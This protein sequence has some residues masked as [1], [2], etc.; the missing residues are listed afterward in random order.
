M[1][2]QADLP[3]RQSR[4]HPLLAFALS[5]LWVGLGQVYVGRPLRA[6][7]LFV[8]FMALQVI[9][10][11]CIVFSS[12]EFKH[13]VFLVGITLLASAY[14]LG[15]RDAFIEGR[16]LG[17]F[18]GSRYKRAVW[19]AAYLALGATLLT[20]VVRIERLYLV[21]VYRVKST[22]MS[23]ALLNGDYVLVN[24]R[25]NCIDCADPLCPGDIVFFEGD[26]SVMVKRVIGLP[27][28]TVEIENQLLSVNGRRVTGDRI[29]SLGDEEL[30]YTHRS[31]S[32][33]AERLGQ[34]EYFSLWGRAESGSRE[35]SRV[36]PQSVFV[37][38]DNRHYSKDSRHFGAVPLMGVRGRGEQILFSADRH[39]GIRTGRMGMPLLSSRC[40]AATASSTDDPLLP[41]KAATHPPP[42]N[43]LI[44]TIDTLRADHVG[45]YGHSEAR[46]ATIDQLAQVSVRFENAVTS[47]PRTTPALASLFTGLWSHNH[48]SRDVG[49][50]IK[51]GRM[52]AEVLKQQGYQTHGVSSTALASG[53]QHFDRGFDDFDGRTDDMDQLLATG[54]TERALEMV[55]RASRTS[56]QFLWV[57]YFDPHFP[58]APPPGFLDKKKASACRQ[59]IRNVLD[60]PEVEWSLHSNWGRVAE[61]VRGDCI[62]LYDA[63]IEYV[64]TEIAQ[65]LHG[66]DKLGYLKSVV[67]VITSDHGESFGESGTYF[68]HGA[69]VSDAVVR[70]PLIITAPDVDAYVEPALFSLEDLTPTL[71]GLLDID[72]SGR[73]AMDGF[74]YSAR[75]RQPREA[76]H[77]PGRVL[78]AEGANSNKP[79]LFALPFDAS[80]LRSSC[81]PGRVLE[82]C[83]QF[84]GAGELL[85]AIM[86]LDARK[87]ELPASEG[88]EGARTAINGRFREGQ[89]RQRSARTQRFKLVQAPQVAGGVQRSLFD[90]ASDPR[91]TIDVSPQFP[92]VRAQLATELDRWLMGLPQVDAHE[93]SPEDL[94][95]LRRLGYLE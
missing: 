56:P 4:L 48:G 49:I 61:R 15:M 62:E 8:G 85:A 46:T 23:P 95:V 37:L 84:G 74:D 38:G 91:E 57:H 55:G 90:L 92:G 29:Q 73:P 64:D 63:E 70:I 12:P 14:V 40:D 5:G 86:G 17:T 7:L 2:G 59:L 1:K 54:V 21:D 80:A 3:A 43:L 58:Y 47:F 69:T 31:S 88:V 11:L 52:L 65:L 78:F 39:S 93:V 16:R 53:R 10:C 76:A 81:T 87:R 68:E 50:P 28:D 45:A 6:L 18:G 20:A 79:P 94:E 83:R 89:A 42:P 75:L 33:F 66:L 24:P 27:G 67:I 82:S 77:D 30:D 13:A 44:I 72:P 41:Q 25:V 36:P 60:N 19:L 71:L 26:A 51:R 35:K 22:S 34:H 9:L 32:A